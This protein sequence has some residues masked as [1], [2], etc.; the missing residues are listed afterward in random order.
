MTAGY[1]YLL[2]GHDLLF[3]SLRTHW[4][5]SGWLELLRESPQRIRKAL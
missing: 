1:A 3:P 2:L 5:V 4:S